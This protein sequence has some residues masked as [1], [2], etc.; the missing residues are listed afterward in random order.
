MVRINKVV[1]PI[2]NRVEK[3]IKGVNIVKVIKVIV[4][5][6][7]LVVIMEDVSPII[8]EILEVTMIL[9]NNVVIL[10]FVVFVKDMFDFVD[11][12]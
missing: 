2:Q 5:K 3:I 4:I 1:I 6:L 10:W 12:V 9:K 7:E 11:Y 8:I